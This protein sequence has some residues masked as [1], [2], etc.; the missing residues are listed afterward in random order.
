MK[1]VLSGL[2][3]MPSAWPLP[4]SRTFGLKY[5]KDL[6]F[7]HMC[8]YVCMLYICILCVNMHMSII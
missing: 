5:F 4:M 3:S 6:F 8:I 7:M 1:G 2:P